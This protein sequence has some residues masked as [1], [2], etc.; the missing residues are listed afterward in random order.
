KVEDVH[1][2][3]KSLVENM[4]AALGFDEKKFV[5]FRDISGDYR[6]GLIDSKAYIAHVNRFG[7]SHLVLE[8]A[9]LL[10]DTEKQRE[11]I[12]AY[13]SGLE[14]SEKTKENTEERIT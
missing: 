1:S 9:Q 7:L 14:C 11:L 6:R 10:P 5:A 4:R 2:A 8:L 12:E 3:N 13:N